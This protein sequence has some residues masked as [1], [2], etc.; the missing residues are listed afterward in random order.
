MGVL[1]LPAPLFNV[2]EGL[3]GF[4]PTLLRLCIWSAVAGAASMLLYGL[5]SP[6]KRIAAVKVDLKAA[7]AEMSAADESFA[8]LME[9]TRKSLGLSFKHLGLVFGPALISAVPMICIMAWASNQYGY[10]F[11]AAGDAVSVTTIPEDAAKELKWRGAAAPT[12]QD[13][14]WTVAWPGE[15]ELVEAISVAG[16]ELFALPLPAPVPTVHKK[17]WWNSLLGNPAGYLA[18]DSPVEVVFLE[19]PSQSHLP[20]GPGWLGHWLTVFLVVSVTGALVT[21][22]V[23]KI[24]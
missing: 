5:M 6:Q 3:I 23:F 15:E 14:A 4:L 22:S 19:L 12:L 7:Q 10:S 13:N 8:E 16:G 24:H 20:F 2:L 11:P 1:D 21:K 18:D 17:L 9:L